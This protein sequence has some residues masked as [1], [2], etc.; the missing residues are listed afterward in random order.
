MATIAEQLTSLANTKTAIKDAIVA[1]G[2]A[3]ADDTPFSGYAAKIGEIQ[4]GGGG[5]PVAKTKYGISID[6]L[7]GEYSETNGLYPPKD[8]EFV[9]DFS[10]VKKLF[11]SA[12]YYKFAA[13]QATWA[14][15]VTKIL[16]PDV[17]EISGSAC[18]GMAKNAYY[19]TEV[20]IP[21]VTIAK[22]NSF[23]SAFYGT[24]NLKTVDISG[25][26]EIS[27]SQACQSMFEA[28][29]IT[30]LNLDNLTTISG[31]NACQYMFAQSDIVQMNFKSLTTISG[32]QACRYMFNICKA[33][34]RVDF[35]ALTSVVNGAFGSNSTFNG[36]FASCT[37]LAEIHFRADAQAMIEALQG[38]S[39][40]WGA[41]SS[42]IYFDL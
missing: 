7:I 21:K 26:T 5:E 13:K 9:A 1:K 28:S 22:S 40:K 39:V 6:D 30:E 18:E 17:E 41:T 35:P 11:S 16:M 31:G 24:S 12:L 38:Y 33:L 20:Y 4:A 42:T 34:I 8:V 29:G 10:G 14:C 2:V 32:S 23:S 19:L 3:V 25:L 37:E 15:G 27:G 36:I